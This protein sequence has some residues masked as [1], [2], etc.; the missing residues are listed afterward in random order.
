M[1]AEQVRD[2]LRRRWPDGEYLM[3]NEASR[4]ADRSGRKLDVLA[5]SFWKSR[6][7]QLDGIEIKVSLSD[8]KREL[9]DGGKADWWWAHTHRF[10]LAVPTD[11]VEKV[12][13]D[14]P[15]TWGLL[16]CDVDG[17]PKAV[18]RADSREPEALPWE[19][20][21]G[22]M[23]CA[24]EA[25]I[26]AL[27]RAEQRGRERGYQEGKAT[28]ERNAE[29]AD[30]DGFAK[31][32]LAQLRESVAVFEKASGI[33]LNME[34]TWGDPERLGRIV[35]AV[36]KE[37]GHGGFTD[38]IAYDVQSLRGSAEHLLKGVA[39]VERRLQVLAKAALDTAPEEE[40]GAN[41]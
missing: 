19:A 31:G 9:A 37:M 7:L 1:I 12:R 17:P 27:G 40:V 2:C 24:S 16:A 38:H 4:H 33:K 25:G 20:C 23:R 15:A 21:V 3:M 22:L 29:R 10:W 41:G 6:G 36:Q 32:Q 30:P 28:A 11:L 8:W 14:L 26:G 39:E 35:A 13:P 34:R 5:V 18:V